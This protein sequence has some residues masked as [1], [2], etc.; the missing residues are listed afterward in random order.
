MVLK[1]SIAQPHLSKHPVKLR[2]I[3]RPY[4]VGVT[5]FLMQLNCDRYQ[6]P[7]ISDVKQTHGG[8]GV[9]PFGIRVIPSVMWNAFQDVVVYHIEATSLRN[10]Q[11]SALNSEDHNNILLLLMPSKLRMQ[12]EPHF[13]ATLLALQSGHN[14]IMAAWLFPTECPVIFFSIWKPC[15]SGH[16]VV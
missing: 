9:S 16:L 8:W 1:I 4:W 6:V 2:V 10:T 3:W 14:S 15:S 5:G 7:I 13:T 12:D 11:G